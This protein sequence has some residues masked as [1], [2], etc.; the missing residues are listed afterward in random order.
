[1]KF[2]LDMNL[3]RGF[4]NLLLKEG[5]SC[6]HVGDIRMSRASDTAI[7]EE[8]R[9][10]QEV[11]ITFDL[12]FGHLLAFSGESTPSV[13]IFRTRNTDLSGMLSRLVDS[14]SELSEPLS[15]G[16]IVTIED[17]SI[18]IRRLPIQR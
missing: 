13:I 3:R 10:S 1:M 15:D 9:K 14:W 6:R 17:Y 18:R 2:L 4:R 7:I 12:D 8:A 11:I 16:A 5:H